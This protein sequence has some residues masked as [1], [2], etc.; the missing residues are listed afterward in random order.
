MG[1]GLFE[2]TVKQPI[3]R[4]PVDASFYASKRVIKFKSREFTKRDLTYWKQY[5]ISKE[6][7]KLFDVRSVHKLL[8]DKNEVTFTVS[9]YN[10]TFAYVVYNKICIFLGGDKNSEE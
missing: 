6:T 10:L 1:I 9:S 2:G 4:R 7:L 3:R 8:N 5:H